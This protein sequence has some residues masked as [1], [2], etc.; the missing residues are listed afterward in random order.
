MY[1]FLVLWRVQ[2]YMDANPTILEPIMDVEITV[3]TEFQGN[4][5]ANLNKRKGMIQNSTSNE[6][7][8][9][10]KANVPLNHM[11]GKLAPTMTTTT[12][13]TMMFGKSALCIKL[14]FPS[15]LSL[16]FAGYATELRS[17]TQGKGEF[18]MEYS[19]HAEVP[20]EAQKEI[21]SAKNMKAE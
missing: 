4:V 13:T 16:R 21:Q 6:A 20:R 11:F 19:Y 7:D 3:P 9:I 10:I 17:L 14:L 18:A 1:I 12:T 2:C 8:T 15:P 5:V